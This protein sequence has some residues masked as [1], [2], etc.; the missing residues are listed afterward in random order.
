MRW[1]PRITGLLAV[2]SLAMDNPH[3]HCALRSWVAAGL[4]IAA[5]QQHDEIAKLQQEYWQV[6]HFIPAKPW[7][8]IYA[9]PTVLVSDML[10][11]ATK[12]ATPIVL[13]NSDIEIE[14]FQQRLL[15]ARDSAAVTVCRR[16]NYSA[17]K[18]LATPEQW[19]FDAFV[20]S[21]HQVAGLDAA[22]YEIGRPVWDYWLPYAL[23][24]IG[25]KLELLDAQL[26]YHRD[27]PQRWAESERQLGI[28]WFQAQFGQVSDWSLSIGDRLGLDARSNSGTMVA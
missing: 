15:A 22:R 21:P 23:R 20:V 3:Q 5:V 12:L 26:L 16:H 14:G 10:A 17:D 24:H 1:Q 18:S 28:D 8:S 4:S 9:K 13:I 25:Y 6:Q 7:Q 19:G 11:V 2:T 27:H